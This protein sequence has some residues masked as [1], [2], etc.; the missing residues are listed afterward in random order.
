MPATLAHESFDPAFEYCKALTISRT[1]FVTGL[2]K[3]ILSAVEILPSLTR[4]ELCLQ[5]PYLHSARTIVLS[6]SYTPELVTANGWF[7]SE[8]LPASFEAAMRVAQAR[9]G[10]IARL[11]V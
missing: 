2:A 11:V 10:V 5:P 6:W 9:N 8:T 3:I 1:C 4:F 7:Q